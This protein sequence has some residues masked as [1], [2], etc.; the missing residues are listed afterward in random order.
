MAASRHATQDSG[1]GWNR[2]LLSCETLSFSTPCRFRP[3]HVAVGMPVARHPPHRSVRADFPHTAPTS[4][5]WRHSQPAALAHS[6]QPL[7]HTFSAL[8]RSHVAL[9]VV[10]LGLRSSL[11]ALRGWLPPLFEPFIGTTPESDPWPA[12]PWVVW[13][14]PSP[15]GL[16]PTT[17]TEADQ[18]SRFS[19]MMFPDVR[20]VSDCAGSCRGI[21][22]AS[23]LV[24]P[25]PFVTGW[26]PWTFSFTAQYPA[27]P[28]PYLRFNSSLATGA[29][30]LGARMD[31][32]S[33]PVRLFHSRHHAGLSRRTSR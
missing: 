11:Q 13:L 21:V 18:V 28:Y 14:L 2:Y 17:A 31:H 3:A 19:C 1:S 25:S 23:L 12:C 8:C 30:K 33:F 4:D 27:H 16:P 26:A 5:E 32:Y 22:I 6:L 10:L 15:T 24:L 9:S 29:A 20:G 7:G